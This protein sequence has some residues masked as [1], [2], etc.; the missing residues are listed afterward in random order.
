MAVDLEDTSDGADTASSAQQQPE[1][2]I[3]VVEERPGGE[4]DT[5]YDESAAEERHRAIGKPFFKPEHN[6]NDL[7]NMLNTHLATG[8]ERTA[9]R[10][11][12]RAG[13][14][15]AVVVSTPRLSSS[16][17]ITPSDLSVPLTRQLISTVASNTL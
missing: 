2:D 14:Q 7:S 8:V 10:V 17:M 6:D 12:A 13:I 5:R 9:K 15:A 16:S 1:A 11:K 4:Q 3:E